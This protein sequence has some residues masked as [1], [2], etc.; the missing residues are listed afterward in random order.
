MS[1]KAW[2][3]AGSLG[4]LRVPYGA[5]GSLDDSRK[6]V[7]WTHETPALKNF[8]DDRID[9]ARPAESSDISYIQGHLSRTP[10]SDLSAC[11]PLRFTCF[12]CPGM[13]VKQLYPPCLAFLLCCARKAQPALAPSKDLNP[14]SHEGDVG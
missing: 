14:Q 12:Y 9:N 2:G 1:Q 11:S 10:V 3:A 13:G 6:T 5:F 4:G 7:P 8:E